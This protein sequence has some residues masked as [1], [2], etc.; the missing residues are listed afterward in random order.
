MLHIKR[1]LFPTDFSP[2]AE[3]A[4][5][6]AAYLASRY[7]AEVRVFNVVT[8]QEA[9][10]MNPMDYLP[11]EA[12]EDDDLVYAAEDDDLAYDTRT[13]HGE[14]SPAPRTVNVH[15][16]QVESIS[17][18]KAIVDHAHEHD[19]D[20]IV[21]GTH[22]RR[23][24]ERLL[25]GSVSEEVVRQ[26]PCPVF[27]IVSRSEPSL[28]P[29]IDHILAPV[30]L[31]GET[32]LV[33][34]HAQALANTYN[35]A[36]SILHVIEEPAFPAVYAI[37]PL[38]PVLQDVQA[39][40]QKA[41]DELAAGVKEQ[42]DEVNVHVAVGYAP[43]DII[44]YAE[45]NDVNCIVLATYGHAGLRR[46]LIGSVAE[47]VVRTATCPVFTVNGFGKSLVTPAPA[48]TPSSADPAE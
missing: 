8:P 36:L 30:D 16:E 17:P 37:N 3:D 10:Q 28:G 6:H 2:S 24:T 42:V 41:L 34:G 23:G 19:I 32:S 18:A 29:P 26:A 40:A 13:E 4:F 22:G 21:M 33:I 14:P 12:T 9:G 35:A 20:L 11:L 38:A 31:S 5:S 46:F 15:Y 48:S 1:I 39:R 45:A 27:S 25:S 7:D 43:Q 47:K 44:D